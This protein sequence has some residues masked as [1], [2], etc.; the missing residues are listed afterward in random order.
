MIRLAAVAV[1]FI[2]SNAQFQHFDCN[3]MPALSVASGT[4]TLL[5]VYATG[6]AVHSVATSE[7]STQNKILTGAS[8]AMGG[9]ALVAL[10]GFFTLLTHICP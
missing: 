9:A 3:K 2:L 10:A 5:L 4:L 1:A 6:E 7:R 8:V